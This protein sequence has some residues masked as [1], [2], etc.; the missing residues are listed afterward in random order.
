[1]DEWMDGWMD[2][3]SSPRDQGVST[4][5]ANRQWVIEA[6]RKKEKKEEEEQETD[7]R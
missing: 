1:M 3:R 4:L 2:G 5:L 6:G 7:P